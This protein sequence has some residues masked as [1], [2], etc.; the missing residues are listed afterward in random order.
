MFDWLW[1]NW[2]WWTGGCIGL[3]LILGV[4]GYFTVQARAERALQKDGLLEALRMLNIGGMDGE[5]ITLLDKQLPKWP[6]TPEIKSAATELQSLKTGLDAALKAGV[7]QTLVAAFKQDTLK[8]LDQL[9]HLAERVAGAG[10]QGVDYQ[11]LAAQMDPYMEQ[12]KRV[13]VA[14]KEARLAL[15]RTSLGDRFASGSELEE[16][17]A[18][19]HNLSTAT[20]ELILNT[21][22]TGEAAG[23]S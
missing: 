18:N 15:A 2:L 20:N 1:T 14:A 7:P 23:K 9:W 16:A 11:S 22:D 17:E 19:L 12:L 3:L 8:A 4:I 10:A 5:I 13:R 21:G 6:I